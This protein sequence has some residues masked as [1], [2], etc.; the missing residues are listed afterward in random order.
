MQRLLKKVASFVSVFLIVLNSCAPFAYAQEITNTPTPSAETSLSPTDTP[1]ETPTE[2]PTLVPT[3]TPSPTINFSPILDQ[4]LSSP[5]ANT[6]VSPQPEQVTPTPDLTS[7][8]A[9]P[10]SLSNQPNAPPVSDSTPTPSLSSNVQVE[11][12]TQGSVSAVILD[13]SSSQ[14]QNLDL[15]T[16]QTSS[17]TLTTDKAD[18]SPTDSAIISG[19]GFSSYTSY[20]LVISSNDPPA[21]HSENEITTDDKGNFSYIYQLDGNYRP[22][23]QVEVRDSTGQ[24]V[25]STTFTDAPASGVTV[26]AATGGTNIPSNKAL[27]GSQSAFTTLGNI[28]IAENA[29]GDFPSPQGV[30]PN[31]PVTLILTAPSGWTFNPGVGSTTTTGTDITIVSTT[32]TSTTITV[33]F[34]IAA[35]QGKNTMTI[36]G[37]QAQASDKSNV[38]GSGNILRTS[39]NPGTAAITG[40]TN[41]STNFGSLSLAAVADATNSTLSASSSTIPADGTTTSIITVTLKDS[42]NN[43]VS[44]KTVTLA[45]SSGAGTPTI[46]TTQGTSDASGVALFTVKSL[47]VGTD[48]FQATDTTD[49]VV[50]TQTA[51]VNFASSIVTITSATGGSSISADTNTT[52]GTATW[53]SLTGPILSEGVTG[54]ITTGTIVLNA[55]TGFVFNTGQAITVLA[56]RTAGT[57]ANSRNINGVASGTSIAVTSQTSSQITLTVSSATTNGVT[58]SLTFQNIQVRPAS[59]TVI[60][61]NITNTGTSTGVSG[62]STNYGTLTEVAGAVSGTN[63][64]IGAS[65]NSV[66]ANGSSNSTITVTVKDAYGNPVSGKTVTLSGNNGNHSTI[67]AASGSSAS[68]GTVTFTVTDTTAESVTYT[69]VADGQTLST[70][71]SVTFVPG[72]VSASTS[73]ASANPS[74]VPADNLTLSTITITLK[75]AFGNIIPNTSVSLSQSQGSGAVITGSPATTNSSGQATFAV[76]STNAGQSA[77]QATSGATT[78]SQAASVNFTSVTQPE[79]TA[80]LNQPANSNGWNSTDVT[81]NWTITDPSSIAVSTSNCG[82]TSVTGETLG[83]DVTCSVTTSLSTTVSKTV[84]VKIDKTKPVITS[85][86]SPFNANGW[87]NTNVIVS[88]SCTDSGS[89]INSNTVAG[90]TLTTEGK[91]QSFTNTGICTDKAGNTADSVP[92]S[93]I[94]IDKTAP[95]IASD[96]P[97][98]TLGNNGWYISDV[99]VPFIGTDNL[100]GFDSSNTTSIDM[101]SKTTAGEGSSITVTSDTL[102][103]QADNSASAILSDSFK[104]DKTAPSAPVASPAG[105]D[106]TTSQSVSLTSSDTLSGLANIYYTT[107]GSTPS[108][109]SGTLYSNPI[110]VGIDTTLKAIAYDSA[111][112]PSAVSSDTYGIAPTISSQTGGRAGDNSITITWNTDNPSTSRII[113]DTVSH[114]IL[115]SGSNYGY[116]SSTIEDPTKV[117][118]HS[119]TVLGLNTGTAYYF[120][121]VSHGSPE[122]VGDEQSFTPHYVFGLPGDGKSDGA[123]TGNGGGNPVSIASVLGA[124]TVINENALAAET[125]TQEEKPSVTK[126]VKGAKTEN[127]SKSQTQKVESNNSVFIISGIFGFFASIFHFFGSIFGK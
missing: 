18:Y 51:S 41:N 55:P 54:S 34:R 2:T 96:V 38:P 97:Q 87:S 32:V 117:N 103:D 25:A 49:S 43:A 14:V 10:N 122:T 37:I 85:S 121:T 5:T 66:I 120:R 19:T 105:G 12:S 13:G 48:V 3:D 36:S 58:N 107:D 20:T 31:N 94:N 67:S 113:Y 44:G 8:T 56:T 11:N 95:S 24:I 42:S 86:Q 40:I 53:T 64:I 70:T 9:A 111:G 81:V 50:I 80:Q 74:A 100:S 61:G 114:P 27:N 110:T 109:T 22:N 102:S 47:T 21:V 68:N 83:T 89:G 73:T 60:N 75:D 76:K 39:A 63:S 52:N 59:G 118:S 91:N 84:T 125:T 78:I 90:T 30:S 15:N 126:E 115:G 72:V 119:V 1:S 82:T 92:V 7:A 57:G 71:T 79:I 98:G 77:F 4:D 65:S 104:I 123:S 28:I 93:G 26:T 116:S 6:D 33:S 29:K 23:Y 112:N 45:K 124:S 88:F 46:T 127:T 108:S 101:T 35:A 16:T 99:T 62:G 69:A 106:F 17:A